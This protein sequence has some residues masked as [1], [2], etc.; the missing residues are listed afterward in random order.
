MDQT[1]S[2][3]YYQKWFGDLK[4][5][6]K[7]PQYVRAHILEHTPRVIK[8]TLYLGTYIHKECGSSQIRVYL[9]MNQRLNRE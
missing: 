1:S 8:D 2:E 5:N 6:N 7:N 3:K 4:L 9:Q